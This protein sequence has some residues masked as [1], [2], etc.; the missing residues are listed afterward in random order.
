V[1][2]YDEPTPAP[3]YRVLVMLASTAGWYEAAEPEKSESLDVLKE[4]LD[5]AEG[6]GARLLASFDDDLFMTGQPTALPYS[7]YILYEVEDLSVVVRFVHR[8]RTSVVGRHLRLEARLGRA[9]FLLTG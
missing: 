2:N 6:E 1:A 3:P 7:I 9:L 5:Q 8:V 4:I